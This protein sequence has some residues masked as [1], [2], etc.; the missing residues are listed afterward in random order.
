MKKVAKTKED[1]VLEQGQ[2]LRIVGEPIIRDAFEAMKDGYLLAFANTKPEEAEK[3]ELAYAHY[4]AVADIWAALEAKARN[5]H[6]RA[7]QAQA[8]RRGKPT[9]QGCGVDEGDKHLPDCPVLAA[10]V[11]TQRLAN[12]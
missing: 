11:R 10:H 1:M 4:K 2:A 9:C 7:L 6:V 8:D 5:V 12:G 3:R